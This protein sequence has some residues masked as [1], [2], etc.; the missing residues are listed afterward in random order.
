L[1]IVVFRKL[2]LKIYGSIIWAI[3]MLWT[4]QSSNVAHKKRTKSQP[5]SINTNIG[6]TAK[7][8]LNGSYSLMHQGAGFI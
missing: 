3:F 5:A 7:I 6:E 8:W 4:I 1:I 2:M